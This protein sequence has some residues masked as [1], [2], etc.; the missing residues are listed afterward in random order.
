MTYSESLHSKILENFPFVLQYFY[1]SLKKKKLNLGSTWKKK[2][3]QYVLIISVADCVGKHQKGTTNL[4]LD[5]VFILGS[6]EL[7]YA[8][9]SSFCLKPDLNQGWSLGIL[10]A[11]GLLACIP[12]CE[13]EQDWARTHLPRSF[14]PSSNPPHCSVSY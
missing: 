14:L 1:S 8:A 12:G 10:L 9:F 6:C 7:L 2:I 3:K 11:L 5:T 4:F 13:A